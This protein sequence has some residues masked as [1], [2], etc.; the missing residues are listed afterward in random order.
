[1]IINGVEL[2]D[3]NGLD[4]ETAQKVEKEMEKTQGLGDKVPKL[5]NSEGIRVICDTVNEI[6]DN[7][8]GEGTSEKVFKG[9]KDLKISMIA[10]EEL[11]KNYYESQNSMNDMIKKY[12][13]N[14]AARRSKK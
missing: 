9:K 11:C 10:F 8:F 7:I 13:P 12:S 5:K 6:F 1:M 4:Y 3:L 2:D 14:R